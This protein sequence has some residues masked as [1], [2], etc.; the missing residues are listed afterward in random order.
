[1]RAIAIR[2]FGDPD[3]LEVQDRPVPH[4]ATGEILVRV[5][6]AGVNRL[7]VLQRKGHYPPLPGASDLPGL[8][9]AGEVVDLGV[10]VG[11][12][13][14]GDRVTALMAGGGYAAYAAVAEGTAIPIPEGLSMVEAASLPE[15]VFTVWH[16]VFER[17]A[18]K[19]GETLL[20][21]G[22]TSG[23]G[24]MAIQIARARGARVIATAGSEEKL[25]ACRALGATHAINYREEDFVSATQAATNGKGADVILDMVG[26]P[27]TAR[28]LDAAA[29]DGRIVQI[30]FL[31]GPKVD[32]D[33]RLIMQKRLVLT[34][35][36][37]RARP[38]GIKAALAEA[39]EREVWPLFA[40][41]R[42]RPVIHKVFPLDQAAEAHALMEEG[43]HIGKIMLEIA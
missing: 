4:P 3:V 21:H 40:S 14:I 43:T 41:R 39:V 35:S 33:L 30:A 10:G 15:T 25:A 13:R 34:G 19:E 20:V 22:G 27:Y 7:D 2:A 29:E 18:L 24:V 32:L 16:N 37:L 26:G 1:M 12:W 11:R 38:T 8:E 31:K 42:V 23:I 6:A 5:A 9:V 28:N 36:T 17:G